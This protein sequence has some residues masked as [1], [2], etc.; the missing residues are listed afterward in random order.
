MTKTIG[1]AMLVATAWG[2]AACAPESSEDRTAKEAA[3][4]AEPQ[5]T[6][7]VGDV[8]PATQEAVSDTQAAINEASGEVGQAYKGTEPTADEA[9]GQAN[10]EQKQP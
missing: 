6:D 1:F 3:E 2:L 9:A 10:Q 7:Y 4:A 8:G 5:N